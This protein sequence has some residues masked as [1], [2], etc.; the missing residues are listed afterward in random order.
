MKTLDELIAEYEA[1]P[2]VDPD[3]I[4]LN[5]TASERFYS[6]DIISF[7]SDHASSTEKTGA[8]TVRD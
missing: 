3:L 1:D 6:A 5:D 8:E 2:K 4:G 7:D